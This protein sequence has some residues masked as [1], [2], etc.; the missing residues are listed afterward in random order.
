MDK[1]RHA[2]NGLSGRWRGALV[3]AS[4]LALVIVLVAAVWLLARPLALLFAAVVIAEAVAPVATRLERWL[5]RPVAIV[6]VY[7][8]LLVAAGAVGW[9][10]LPPLVGQASK[11]LTNGP[12]LIAQVRVWIDHWDPG[13][14]GRLAEVIQGQLTGVSGALVALPLTIVSSVLE[15]LL[16]LF[17]SVY[18]LLTAP[19]LHRFVRSLVA[20]HRQEEVDDVLRE[21]GRTIGGFVR[22]TVIDALIVA[23]VVYVGL[24]VIGVDFPL[25]LALAAAL[26]E[27][28]R[29]AGPIIAAVPALAIALLASPTQAVLVLGFYLVLQQFESHVLMPNIM[30]KQAD[31]PPLLAILALLAGASLAGILGALV[32]IPLAGALRVVVV[33]VA[34]PAVRRWSGADGVDGEVEP[35][36]RSG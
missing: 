4:A 19:K 5:P 21:I 34:S 31:V 16:V 29:V 10:T 18:W 30:H 20:K 11:L 22:A 6:L 28:I 13:G 7:L 1:S 36:P 3:G 26:G 24:R 32:A 27:L 17:M 23:A 15:I 9:F 8:G 25:V 12:G 2:H 14:G 33:R 35:V